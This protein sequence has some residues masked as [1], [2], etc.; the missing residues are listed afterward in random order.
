MTDYEKALRRYKKQ[1]RRLLLVRTPAAKRFLEDLDGSI[2]DY[3]EA[4]GA[5]DFRRVEEHFGTPEEVARSFFAGTDIS[6]VR[7]RL[8]LRRALLCVLLAALLAWGAAVGALYF[9]ARSDLHG[10]Y[11]ES[12][13]LVPAGEVSLP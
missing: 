2:A 8:A 12:T 13:S 4:E 1:I 3:A 10:A 9:E 11:T 7:R 5:A 6:A